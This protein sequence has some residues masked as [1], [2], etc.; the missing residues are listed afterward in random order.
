[1]TVSALPGRPIRPVIRNESDT[2]WISKRRRPVAADVSYA[3]L[4]LLPSGNRSKHPQ[5]PSLTTWMYRNHEYLPQEP[6]GEMLWLYAWSHEATDTK[7]P[8]F[9]YLVLSKNT[10]WQYSLQPTRMVDT[11]SGL[12][13]FAP[14]A[15]LFWRKTEPKTTYTSQIQ[16]KLKTALTKNF[17]YWLTQMAMFKCKHASNVF[18][19]FNSTMWRI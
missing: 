13:N 2:A 1:M 9:S 12:S 4:K 16:R 7:T 8:G 14:C 19:R 15:H 17:E 6:K 3:V 18:A 10:K 5:P 11:K